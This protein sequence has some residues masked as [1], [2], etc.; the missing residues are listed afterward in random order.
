M[1][2]P[3]TSIISSTIERVQQ[4]VVSVALAYTS[5]EQWPLP[6]IR[7]IGRTPLRVSVL[8][9]SFNPPTLAHLALANSQNPF[10]VTSG[11]DA[12]LLL[13]SVRNADKI[14]QEG[15]ATLSQR[16]EM[17]YLLATKVQSNDLA[18][19][20]NVAVGLVNEPAFTAKSSALRRFLDGHLRKLTSDPLY[21]PSFQ[22][23]FLM[24]SS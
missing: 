8:D 17:M 3:T 22:V 13:L 21:T 11:Y 7:S 18:L 15:D 20:P 5:H 23:T 6:P 24:G 9:S 19:P 12:T 14:L 2:L 10:S 4:Q 16:V 1:I